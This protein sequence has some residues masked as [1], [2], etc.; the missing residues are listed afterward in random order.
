MRRNITR[1]LFGIV[2]V[3]AAVILLGN[4]LHWW[5]FTE[6]KGW[7][8]VFLIIPGLGAIITYGFSV[9][10]AALVLIGGWFLAD[11]QGWIPKDVSNNI[12]WILIL[13]LIGVRLIVGSFKGSKVPSA[14]VILDGVKGACDSSSTVNYSAV[15][16]AVEVANNSLSLCGGTVSAVLG[17][18][19]IDLR[20]AVPV[21]GAV[22]QAD[23]VLG[24]VEIIVP[25]NCRI[26]VHGFPFFG[27]ADCTAV[28]SN[29]PSLPLL[30]IK[31]TSVFGSVGVK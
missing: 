20:N 6:F 18:A 1:V 4:S 30:T 28:R 11:A 19:K 24:G 21:D 23:A 14:P 22:I 3:F 27:G 25:Q 10:S 29:D 9:W 13:F 26:Q 17:G 8:T 15:L 2:L 5:S 12:I 31:Y 7:W 16:G